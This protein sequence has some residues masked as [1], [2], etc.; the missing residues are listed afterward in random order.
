MARVGTV[1]VRIRGG[2]LLAAVAA[3]KAMVVGALDGA[4]RALM[5][6]GTAPPDKAER[7]AR[8]RRWVRADQIGAVTRQLHNECFAHGFDFAVEADPYSKHM[9][10]LEAY[11]SVV[12]ARIDEILTA[13]DVASRR[14]E[15]G[16]LKAD[17]SA[18]PKRAPPRPEAPEERI[19]QQLVEL[20][21]LMRQRPG[22]ETGERGTSRTVDDER[23][24]FHIQRR[25][26]P[27]LQTDPVD[28]VE[29][30]RTIQQEGTERERLER[31]V[32]VQEA[33][34]ARLRQEKRDWTM[35]LPFEGLVLHG[36][37]RLD[38]GVTE[39]VVEWMKNKRGRALVF[40]AEV[41]IER[42]PG[43]AA[44]VSGGGTEGPL[45]RI[46]KP[47]TGFHAALRDYVPPATVA[48]A[49]N[50]TSG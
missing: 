36:R 45:E 9:V 25:G 30:R 10:Y 6:A 39:R 33:E 40:D 29:L 23:L 31:L 46:E 20:R 41:R 35:L 17:A 13:L 19:E 21:D 11:G 47:A 4:A 5:D 24:S 22:C 7:V 15:T 38:S 49:H 27:L 3:M 18:P 12:D 34:L 26:A 43:S 14:A 50:G 2:Y 32:Q 42:L 37:G 44:Q 48:A 1:N 8:S 16:E 28:V